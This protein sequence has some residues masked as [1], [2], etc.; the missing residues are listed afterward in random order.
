MKVLAKLLEAAEESEPV[1][2]MR[3][4]AAI[5]YKNKIVSIGTNK[6]K[7]HPIMDKFKKNDKAI[8]LHA[9]VDAINKAKKK[10]DEN[11]LRKAR[12]YVIRLLKDGSLGIACP[13]RGC[14]QCI[15]HYGIKTVFYSNKLGQIKE[16]VSN[17]NFVNV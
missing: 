2:K 3:L 17:H 15:S 14:S 10:L 9:E 1:S 12:L 13:C 7:T 5:V 6:Y 11:Q 4:A 8:F 16:H